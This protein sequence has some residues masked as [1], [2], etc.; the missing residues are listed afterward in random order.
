MRCCASLAVCLLAL[1][2]AVFF[3]ASVAQADERITNYIVIAKVEKDGAL[4]V[5][6]RIRNS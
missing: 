6:E 5:R 2:W 1:V 4:T 3:P